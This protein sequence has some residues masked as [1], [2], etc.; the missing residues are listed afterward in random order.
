MKGWQSNLLHSTFW[1]LYLFFL[2][3]HPLGPC[4]RA[5]QRPWRPGRSQPAARPPSLIHIAGTPTAQNL[6]LKCSMSWRRSLPSQPAASQAQSHWRPSP[7]HTGPGISTSPNLSWTCCIADADHR[8]ESIVVETCKCC[9]ASA[10]HRLM[11]SMGSKTTLPQNSSQLVPLLSWAADDP[12]AQRNTP[13]LRSRKHRW[14]DLVCEAIHWN[15][16][17]GVEI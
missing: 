13:K 14:N 4:G 10:H 15:F 5:G 2:P 8:A 6:L 9:G 16:E 12:S 1:F 17:L 7:P 11:I 3:T